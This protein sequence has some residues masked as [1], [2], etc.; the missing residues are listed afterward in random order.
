MIIDILIVYVLLYSHML[1]TYKELKYIFIPYI[2][3]SLVYLKGISPFYL[4]T[5]KPLAI[6]TPQSS[7]Y[8]HL[9]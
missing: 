4:H 8:R 6:L 5:P 9:E 1:T 7:I 2:L 3:S